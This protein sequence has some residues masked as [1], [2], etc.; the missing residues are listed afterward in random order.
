MARETNEAQRPKAGT[1]PDAG[2]EKSAQDL[3]QGTRRH[4][5][6]PLPYALDALEPHMSAETL[7]FHHGKHHKTYVDKLNELIGG[8]EYA[9]KDLEEIIRSAKGPI[10][11][12][13]AQIWNHTFFWNCLSPEGGGKPKGALAAA[14]DKSF[15]SFD[16]FKDEFTKASVGHFASGWAWLTR[17]GSGGLKI[18]AL[19]NAETPVM[20][21]DRVVLTC[22]LWEHAYY[23]DY[24]NARPEFLKAFWKIVNWEFADK[25]YAALA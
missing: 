19:P 15:G 22:D 18:E 2:R 7:Q 10:F 4:E 21:K 8:T 5:L 11:N 13:A 24:R 14:I 20:R 12:N 25:S 1:T 6:P 9:N 23:I 17:D 16:G 3:L